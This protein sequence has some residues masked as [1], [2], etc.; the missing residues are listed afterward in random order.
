GAC[1]N[2]EL[3]ERLRERQARDEACREMTHGKIGRGSNLAALTEGHEMIAEGREPAFGRESRLE[4]VE[5]AGTIRVVLDILPPVPEQLDR[6]ARQL[7]DHGRFHH[8]V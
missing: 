8:E 1:R 2:A 6:P 7:R 3:D 5:S 4:V